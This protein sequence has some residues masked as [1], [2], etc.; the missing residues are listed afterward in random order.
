[1]EPIIQT[2]HIYYSGTPF[3][4]GELVDVVFTAYRG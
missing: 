4:H 2:I 1:M 3:V